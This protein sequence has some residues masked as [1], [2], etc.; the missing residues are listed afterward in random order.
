MNNKLLK[1]SKQNS[2][3]YKLINQKWQSFFSRG[4]N[5]NNNSNNTTFSWTFLFYFFFSW[6]SVLTWSWYAND[7]PY[8]PIICNFRAI[9]SQKMHKLG[10]MMIFACF[11]KLFDLF[12]LHQQHRPHLK[13]D[14]WR[15]ICCTFA[16]S[17]IVLPI[18]F[19]SFKPYNYCT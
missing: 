5:N 14:M 2:F 13:C 17:K 7:D 18:S 10:W 15:V 4:C 16:I 11:S 3:S 19:F 9:F 6:C 8:Y 1:F 12:I